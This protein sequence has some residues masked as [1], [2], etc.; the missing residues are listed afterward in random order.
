MLQILSNIGWLFSDRILRL[1]IGLAVGVWLARYL[2]PED[3]GLF[4]FAM[5]FISM[6]GALASLGL[7]GVVV[8]DL[9]K[10][11]EDA[12]STLGTAFI[13]RVV[14]GFLALGMSVLVVSL[15]RPDDDLV[16][17]IVAILGFG[18]IAK[19]A[20]VVKFWFE[21]QVRSKYTVW[22][23]N[24][25]FLLMAAVRI[26]LILSQAPLVFFA[27]AALVEV[28]VVSVLLMIIYGRFGGRLSL[29]R[30]K[31]QR[32]ITLVKE[33]WPLILSGIA[34]IVYMR[35]DQ[36]MLGQMIG[37]EAVGV[38]SVAVR[39][40]EVWYFV[41]F[42]IVAS[43]YPSIIKAKERDESEYSKR[44]QA[45]YDVAV[46]ISLLVAVPA[47]LLAEPVI[48]LLFGSAYASSADVFAVH[49]WT[50]LFVFLGVASAKWFVIENRQF[51]SFQRTLLGAVLNVM[52]NVYMIPKYGA[53]GAAYATLL[54]QATAAFLFDALRRDTRRMFLLKLRSMNIVAAIG[55]VW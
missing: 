31:F 12:N 43:V 8:R 39:L 45:L 3:F 11:P 53:V 37:D 28:A 23:E 29:W 55:R 1:V 10:K 30:W 47:S 6:F 50:G 42:A 24:G 41:P 18:M 48:T 26:V 15:V 27:W 44:W 34:A 4:N 17:A 21:S 52:L 16:K 36:I 46:L 13:L 2:G 19:A 7:N 20:E 32:G 49:I 22:V 9:V 14:S 51:L 35:V 38:Y 40:S 5:A 33:S 25:V 54:A